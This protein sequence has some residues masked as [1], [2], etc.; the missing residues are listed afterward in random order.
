MVHLTRGT[1]RMICLDLDG[2]LFTPRK[3]ISG[4][5]RK[6]IKGCLDL[7]MEVVL[8]TGRPYLFAKGVAASIDPRVDAIGYVGNY[9]RIQ[10]VAQ[11]TPIPQ[12]TALE[13]LRLLQR[14]HVWMQAKTFHHVYGNSL[15]L[16]QPDYQKVTRHNP[17]E[18][19]IEVHSW[20]Q[21][22]RQ[23]ERSKEPVYKI[24]AL[25]GL[26]IK[27]LNRL[28]APIPGIKVY[29]YAKTNL[30]ITSDQ[31]DKGTAIQAAAAQLGISLEQ[32]LGVGDSLN[33]MEMFNVCGIK[34]AMGN[35]S[36]ALKAQADLITDSN[37]QEG[38][39]K[40]LESVL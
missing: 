23:I 38:V 30:E 32:V 15:N 27:K 10:G 6:A 26:K 24:I 39:A 12:E 28:L 25:G 20:T 5:S 3:E 37:A 31:N 29:S 35:A 19:Q 9:R 2:T 18:E 4:R 21:P 1:V 14:E 33:D 13:I 7:G 17:P 11:G 40:L 34:A 8:V 16:I 22:L 36:S